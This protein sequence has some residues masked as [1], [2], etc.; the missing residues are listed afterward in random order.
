MKYVFG[1]M[2]SKWSLEAP[3]LTLAKLAMMAQIKNNVPIAIYEPEDAKGGFMPKEFLEENLPRV[4]AG[5]FDAKEIQ[6]IIKTIKDEEIVGG[7]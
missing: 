1:V 7:N 4:M 3:N 2:S 6:E 5:E